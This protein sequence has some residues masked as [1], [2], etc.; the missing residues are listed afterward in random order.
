[1]Q[2]LRWGEQNPVFPCR[3][4]ARR[5]ARKVNGRESTSGAKVGQ[6]QRADITA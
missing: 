6:Y 2:G 3:W 1:M 4:G 5:G